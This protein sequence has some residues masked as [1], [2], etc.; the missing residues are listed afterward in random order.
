MVGIRD[1][2][3][4]AQ[5]SPTTVSRLLNEDPTLQV[6]EQTRQRVLQAVEQLNYD[7]KN[8]RIKQQRKPSIGVISTISRQAEQQ[9]VYYQQLRLGMEL[10][11]KR[12]HLGMNRIYN[13]SED[14]KKWHDL[15]Q[16]GAIIV[17]GTVTQTV[18]TQL[19]AQN[20]HVIVVDNPDIKGEVDLVYADI[21]TTT[22]EILEL[23]V[24]KGHQNLAY[25]GGYRLDLDATGKAQVTSDE[26][27]MRVFEAFRKKHAKA[28]HMQAYLGGWTQAE[29]KRL[30][31]QILTTKPLPSA[32][33]I[34]S[35]PLAIG[36]YQALEQTKLKIG[37][38]IVLVSFDDLAQI[39]TL[40]PSLTS[41]SVNAKALGQ[42]AVRLA[43]EWIDGSRSDYVKLIYP[44]KI[45]FRASFTNK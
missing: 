33:L 38:D 32:V 6:S 8:Y 12:L 20:P 18:I 19:K 13:L 25:L 16:L 41:V 4:K 43:L 21:E 37:Q 40:N 11:A 30:M 31:Q 26:K 10:E 14:P 39:A 23:F 45:I 34:A 22:H 5:V 2:A 7:L 15:D 36:A 1:V 3:R 44:A 17:I 24:A 9:D 35:D 28:L 42:S 29:G 27:R